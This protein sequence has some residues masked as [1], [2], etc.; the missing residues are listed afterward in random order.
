M[1]QWLQ[2]ANCVNSVRT[3]STSASTSGRRPSHT[4]SSALRA[5]ETL[6]LT[7]PPTHPASKVSTKALRQGWGHHAGCPKSTSYMQRHPNPNFSHLIPPHQLHLVT[8]QVFGRYISCS[9]GYN[10][11][12]VLTQYAHCQRLLQHQDEDR[13][14]HHLQP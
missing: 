2:Y 4:P 5:I 7:L 6:G 14:T 8:R 13:L 12:T 1:Q 3:L 10:M 11:L 9:S